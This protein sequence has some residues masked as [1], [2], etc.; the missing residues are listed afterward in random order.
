MFM[1]TKLFFTQ[2]RSG[3]IKKY[4]KMNY[5]V[6]H[7]FPLIFVLSLFLP[8]KVFAD[9]KI[10]LVD[11][12]GLP[13]SLSSSKYSNSPSKYSNSP[14]KYSNSESK[15]SNSPSKYSNSSSKYSN[16]S[17]GKN[18]LLTENN[19]YVGYYVFT[20]DDI[21]NFFNS[22]GKRIAYNPNLDETQSLFHSTKSKWCGTFGSFG[23]KR[24][25]GFVPSCY[26]R[27]VE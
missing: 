3:T 10:I 23:G 8:L 9:Y 2:M 18:R 26:Y 4:K 1:E 12:S 20:D 16:G 14:S 5:Y 17:S 24:V 21:I 22:E 25:I 15:Y 7:L 11:E 13:H 27:F 19:E 6:K